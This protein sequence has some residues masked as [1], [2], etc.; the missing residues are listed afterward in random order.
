MAQK[1]KSFERFWKELKRRKV[2]HVITVYAAIAFVILQLVDMVAEPLRLPVSTKALVIVLLCIGFIIAV[3]LS[4]VY[5]ITPAGV[6]KTKPVSEL[7]HSDHTTHVVSSGW[8][9]ATYISAVIIIALVAFNIVSRRNLNADISKLEK[10]IA[11]LPFYNDSPSDSTSYFINGLM[12]EILNNLHRIKAF[13]K[14]LARSS[15]EQYRGSIRPTIQQIGKEQDVNYIVEG[16]GQKYGNTFRLR[17]QLIETKN[18]NHL[19]AESYER[20]IQST[21][22]IYRTQ[23]EIAQSIASALKATITPEEK[24]LIEKI[25]TS[26]MAALDLYL[27]A[28]HFLKEYEKTHDLSS[29]QTAV[30]LYNAA[31]SIDT[32]YAKAYTGLASAYYD[33][34]QWETYF[35]E[36]YLD[37]ML[38]LIDK[39]LDIDDQLDEAYYLKGRY[40]QE[41][42]HIEDALDNYD[43]T[44]KIDPN[45]YLAYQSKGDLYSRVLGD[46]VNGLGNYHKALTLVRGKERPAL[47][48][49]LGGRYMEIGFT[50][51]AKYYYQE[52]FEQDSNKSLHFRRLAWI[53]FSLEN[54]EET[55]KLVKQGCEIDS[56][57]CINTEL[58][59]FNVPSGH[60]E[61]AYLFAKKK[62]EQYK[63]MG[64]IAL[65][66]AFQI[67]YSFWQVGQYQEAKNYFNQQI[68]YDE[69]SIRLRR[70]ISQ[71]GN[72]Q[73]DLASTYAFLGEK[74]KAYK[75]LEEFVSIYFP[76]LWQIS[77]TKHNP[78]M[79]SISNEER[80]KKLLQNMEAKYQAEHERVRKWLEETGQ[81]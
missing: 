38:V 80:Y 14:V 67:G 39:A 25:P 55:L 19:W 22:N 47:L 56:L 50:D 52:A 2:I 54:F 29:Y 81:L 45:H 77:Y 5:D 76:K 30:N 62:I 36:N 59:F 78:F 60:K 79:K 37:S 74:A 35:K 15:M 18:G 17:V 68:K 1:T 46:Y 28:N 64:T 69:E 53:E 32:A 6:K 73:Y 70:P 10:S 48:G 66:T 21:K 33:R 44:L 20:E 61:E 40:Y 26:S 27:K 24:Q 34:Y 4:W 8:G 49:S 71:V 23:S 57:S 43:K 63:R 7:K 31:L 41:N 75:Y 12:D 42:G 72:A 51:K 65:Q 3:F 13:S 11:V 16:S 58:M 9:I